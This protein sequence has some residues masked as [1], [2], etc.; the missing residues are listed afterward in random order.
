[1]K[2]KEL[3]EEELK[4][5][6]GGSTVEDA[7]NDFNTGKWHFVGFI[8]KYA[9]GHIGQN[10][11][12]VKHDGSTYYYG[13]LEDS[14]EAE[15]TFSTERTQQMS[16][17]ERNGVPYYGIIEVSGDDYWLYSERIQ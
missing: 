16:C 3:T 12:L 9:E 2:N 15:F 5:V 6:T 7:P 1:M 14:F 8:G 11:Y 4:T 17:V 10:L 13:T